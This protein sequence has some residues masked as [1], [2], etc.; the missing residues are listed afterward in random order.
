MRPGTG[1]IEDE[2][3]AMNA[4]I[5]SDGTCTIAGMRNH[6]TPAIGTSRALSWPCAPEAVRLTSDEI[7]VWCANLGDFHGELPHFYGLLSSA[8]RGPSDF[9]SAKIAMTASFATGCFG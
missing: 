2:G 6:T 5:Q 4:E 7:H 9:A 3:P 8:E 1:G